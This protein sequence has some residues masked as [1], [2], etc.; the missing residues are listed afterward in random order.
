MEK[1]P[2]SFGTDFINNNG[3]EINKESSKNMVSG[4]SFADESAES[5]NRR[6][7]AKEPKKATIRFLALQ[8]KKKF[9]STDKKK[10]KLCTEVNHTN[11]LHC[12]F[13]FFLRA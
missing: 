1:L 12:V 6:I 3:L 5:V 2:V 4:S 7:T 9:E 11:E 13:F 10:E 8:K